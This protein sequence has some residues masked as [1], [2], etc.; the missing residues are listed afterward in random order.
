MMP[1]PFTSLQTD[2]TFRRFQPTVDVGVEVIVEVSV[3][4]GVSV[5]VD[6]AVAGTT[7]SVEGEV[8][9]V[10]TRE[11]CLAL[12]VQATDNPTTNRV[13]TNDLFFMDLN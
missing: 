11:V 4:E 1:Y 5:S 10:S 7:V 3:G 2:N 9:S 13:M 8:I 6:V 12:E